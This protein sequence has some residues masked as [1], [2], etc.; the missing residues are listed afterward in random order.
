MSYQSPLSQQP[1]AVPADPPDEGVAA[2]YGEPLREQR[3]LLEDRSGYVD[4]SHRDVLR[5]TGPDRLGWLHALTT[6]HLEV[7]APGTSTTALVLSAN[8]HVEHA[9]YAVD[10]GTAFWAH[11]EPGT[12]GPLVEYLDS[13]RFL[14]RVEVADVS[15]EY[16]VCWLADPDLSVP[17]AAARRSGDDSLGGQEVL[18]PRAELVAT[19]EALGRPAAGVWAW[20]AL[21]IAARLPR[22]GRETDH[23]TIPNE[24]GWLDTGVHLNKGC[25]RGQ[26]TVARVH[27]LGKPPRR[28]TFLHLDGSVDRLPEHGSEVTHGGRAIGFVTSTARHVDLGPIGLALVRRNVPVDAELLA[29]GVAGAQEVVVDPDVGLHARPSLR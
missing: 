29:D 3:R 21:R 5:V 14:S 1:E 11:V 16:A 15:D 2:H 13:M 28:L 17:G 26:E 18:L 19:V 12:A 24:I 10:D 25:Y 20:E 23:R 8:G 7:L 27:T 9:M 6:Q 22:L 4:L